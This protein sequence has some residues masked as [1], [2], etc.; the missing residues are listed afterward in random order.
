MCVVLLRFEASQFAAMKS[1]HH[2]QPPDP[3][4]IILMLVIDFGGAA[5][6]VASPLSR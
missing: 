4:I 3:E 5:A 2:F 1:L 6:A